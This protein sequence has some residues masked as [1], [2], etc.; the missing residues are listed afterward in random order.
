MALTA[1]V[2]WI[3]YVSGMCAAIVYP[4]VGIGLY[5]LVYHVNPTTQWWG[6]SFAQTGI[7]P[8]L[9][10]ALATLVGILLRPPRM[11]NG[12]RQFPAPVVCALALIGYALLSCAWAEAEYTRTAA[13]AE[14]VLK[15]AIFML[16]LVRCVRTAD[17]YAFVFLSWIIG[18]TYIGYEACGGAGSMHGGRLTANLGGPDFDESSGL[19]VHLVASLPLI[20]A[21]F[22]VA[23]KWWGRLFALVS[24]AMTVNTIVMTR[25]R[26][27]VFGVAAM[28]VLAV[29]WLPRGYRLKGLLAIG[30][31]LLL[32]LRLT[33][34]LWWQ[35]M[36]TI[37]DYEG[38]PSATDRLVYWRTALD[39]AKENPLGIGLGQF[40]LKYTEYTEDTRRRGAHSTF[41]SCLAELG[42]P[43]LLLLM[44]VAGVSLSR[45][46]QVRSLSYHLPADIPVQL[47]RWTSRFHLGWHAMALQSALVAYLACG[48]FTTRLWTEGFWILIGLSACLGNVARDL[49]A[50]SARID[51]TEPAN[52]STAARMP[53]GLAPPATQG[54]A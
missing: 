47:G 4:L 19:A 45:L 41:M 42:F 23:R 52:W 9:S 24:G 25:T 35:R 33:D 2:F 40:H 1:I 18:V 11:G 15:L 38:D 6:S 49:Q 17:Q 3:A 50:R 14:K 53:E 48:I 34:P 31:G 51:Q 39:M 21:L 46:G 26:N 7:R 36:R 12:A 20:G 5:V 29:F 44:T 28:A 37:Q 27:A 8:S 22:F 10:I 13:T 43:G 16:M 32:T 54:Q 30:V